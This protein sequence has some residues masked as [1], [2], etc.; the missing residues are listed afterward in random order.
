VFFVV[1][2]IGSAIPHQ[3]PKNCYNLPMRYWIFTVLAALIAI[4]LWYY[5]LP[6][7]NAFPWVKKVLAGQAGVV[8]PD[9]K[10]DGWRQLAPGLE[11]CTFAPSGAQVTAVRAD[12][13]RVKMCVT[14]TRSA[15][16]ALGSR[17]ETVCPAVGVAINASMFGEDRSPLGLLVINSKRMQPAFPKDNWGGALL[18]RNGKVSIVPLNSKTP[19][20]VTQ[21]IECRPRLVIDGVIPGFK[22]S[23]GTMRAA[24]GVDKDGLLLL[25]ASGARLTMEQW[26][27]FMRDELHCIDALN[28]DG[29]PSAQ[30]A[31][32]GGKDLPSVPSQVPVPVFITLAPK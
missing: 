9:A 19:T 10:T 16:N 5:F 29:G 4:G 6:K 28:F 18:L 21:G 17:A 13:S 11:Y 25:A 7:E 12:L 26:A 15:E 23:N 31:M 24:G 20:G 30:L 1:K 32:N 22:P 3:T 27:A 2:L 8:S 14:D